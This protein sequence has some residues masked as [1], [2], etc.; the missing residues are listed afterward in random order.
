MKN[1]ATGVI[2]CLLLSA[3]NQGQQGY[4]QGS[5]QQAYIPSQQYNSQPQQQQQQQQPQQAVPAAPPVVQQKSAP[6]HAHADWA[7]NDWTDG[8]GAAL[9]ITPLKAGKYDVQMNLGEGYYV[10]NGYDSGRSIVATRGSERIE[11][12]ATSAAN[13]IREYETGWTECLAVKGLATFCR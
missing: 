9:V 10:W 4:N 6:S 13:E 7:G 8:E 5:Q 3:C 12:V 1:I 2:T 11:L